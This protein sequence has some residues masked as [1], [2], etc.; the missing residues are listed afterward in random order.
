MQNLEANRK[1]LYEEHK[2]CLQEQIM[3][4][5]MKTAMETQERRRYVKTHFGPEESE[6]RSK[7][8][9]DKETQEKGMWSGLE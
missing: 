5:R 8:H 3:Q 6:Q 1:K 7:L 2:R 4:K 9:S